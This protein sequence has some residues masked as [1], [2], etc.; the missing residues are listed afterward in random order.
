MG[1][2]FVDAD[3]TRGLGVNVSVRFG[4]GECAREGDLV[5]TRAKPIR[6]GPMSDPRMSWPFRAFRADMALSSRSKLMN[7]QH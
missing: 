3:L 4:S 2:V 6:M 1:V 7:P 5:G